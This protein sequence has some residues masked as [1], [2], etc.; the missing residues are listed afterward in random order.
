MHEVHDC[1]IVGGGPAGLTAA[2]YL[3]RFCRKPLVI[4]RGDSRARLI[5]M[6]HNHPGFLGISGADLLSRMQDQAKSYGA[7]LLRGEVTT[8]DR[9]QD[10]IF[11]LQLQGGELH[12]RAVLIASGLTDRRPAIP[13]LEDVEASGLVRYCPICDGYEFRNRRIAVLGGLH[14]AAPKARFL[15][16]FSRSIS[17]LPL[18]SPSID[19][20]G[21]SARLGIDVLPSPLN[22]QLEGETATIGLS[23][24]SRPEF[25]CIYV[26]CGCDVHSTLARSLGIACDPAGTIKVDDK[27]QST[28]EGLYAAGDVVSDLHQICVA[29]AHAAIAASAIHRSLPPNPAP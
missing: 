8:I 24:G 4:D 1:I 11:A 9:R 29:E 23:D 7:R 25:D 21:E 16:T 6:S 5:P 19:H 18:G 14:D 2:T 10:G 3:G 28:V 20:E 26:A 15:R 12:A 27:Q 13:G 17:I 22:M